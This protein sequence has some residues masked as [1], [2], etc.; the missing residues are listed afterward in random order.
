MKDC[1]YYIFF[2]LDFQSDILSEIRFIETIFSGE[3]AFHLR[4]E[5]VC[6]NPYHYT[7]VTQYFW[8]TQYQDSLSY[9]GNITTPKLLMY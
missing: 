3:Y 7:K 9:V 4:R 1:Y 5:E 2:F 6:V 8:L